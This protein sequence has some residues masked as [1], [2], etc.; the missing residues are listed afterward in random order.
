MRRI[1]LLSV[2]ILLVLAIM[3]TA[4]GCFGSNGGSNTTPQTSTPIVVKP[5]PRIESVVA[6]TSGNQKAYYVT[7]DIKVKNEGAKGTVLVQA[8]VTQSGVT[9]QNEMAIFLKQG[10]SHELEMTFPLVWQ[11]GV[12]TTNVQAIVP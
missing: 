12:F 7:L 4:T 1:G 9:N 10:D 11:G 8:S 2:A 3:L 6:T 5:L